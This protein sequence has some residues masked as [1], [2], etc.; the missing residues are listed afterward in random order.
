MDIYNVAAQTNQPCEMLHRKPDIELAQTFIQCGEFYWNTGIVVGGA[1]NFI[2]SIDKCLPE[3][4]SAFHSISE[5][6]NSDNELMAL[7][8]IYSESPQSRLIMGCWS[9]RM[10]YI[11]TWVSLDG[12]MSARGDR[13]TSTLVKINMLTSQTQM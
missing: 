1:K 12:A 5:H 11:C 7:E 6:L 4:G 10:I 13:C 2:D 9:V 3:L 8:S